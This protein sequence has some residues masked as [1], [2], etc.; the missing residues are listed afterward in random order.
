MYI[1]KVLVEYANQSLD[2]TFDYLS[3]QYVE[4]DV[5]WKYLFVIV[6]LLVM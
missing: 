6:Q 1:L 5:V 4:Q 2:T 3:N